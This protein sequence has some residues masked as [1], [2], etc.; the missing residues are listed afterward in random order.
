MYSLRDFDSSSFEWSSLSSKGISDIG[1]L[2]SFN[3][4]QANFF[5]VDK[6]CFI[7]SNLVFSS[8]LKNEFSRLIRLIM[9][10][11]TAGPLEIISLLSIFHLLVP[12]SSSTILNI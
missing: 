1:I 5:G 12:I 11:S 10:N 8:C 9:V 6:N 3:G 2:S 7:S 4:M